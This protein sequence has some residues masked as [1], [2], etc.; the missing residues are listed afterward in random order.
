MARAI[1]ADDFRIS[2]QALLKEYGDAA[3]AMIAEEAQEAGD[4]CVKEISSRAPARSGKY[5][6]SFKI[7]QKVRTAFGMSVIVGASK[8][9]YRLTH[10]LEHGHYKVLWGKDTGGEVSGIPHI[11]PAEAIVS[12]Q[13]VDRVK[14]RIGEL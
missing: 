7:Q 11:G 8:P 1:K 3:V 9:Y 10:L 6:K 2:V 5:A 12:Q 14:R 4:L 13:F